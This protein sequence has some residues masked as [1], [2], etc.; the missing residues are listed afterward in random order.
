MSYT[1]PFNVTGS[2][3]VV[4]PLTHSEEGLPIGVQVVGRRWHDMKLLAV[5]KRLAERTAP[6]RKPP[7]Y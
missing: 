4:L 2:P 7:G 5:A 3:V 6:F 1:A